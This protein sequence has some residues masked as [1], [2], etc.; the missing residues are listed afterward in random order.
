MIALQ[1][2]IKYL[3]MNAIVKP[4]QKILKLKMLM[5]FIVY[6]NFIFIIIMESLTALIQQSLHVK[7]IVINIQIQLP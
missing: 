5:I 2:V 1:K 4:V 3:I 7:K 6:A